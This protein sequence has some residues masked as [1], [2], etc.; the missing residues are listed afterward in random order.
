MV[1]NWIVK[2]VADNLSQKLH[3]KVTVKHVDFSL[4]NKMHIEGVL[5]ED[6]K[7]DTLLYA[8]TMNVNITDWFFFKD[9]ATLHYVGLT[10]AVINLNRTDSVWNYQFIADYFSSPKNKKTKS[11]GGI[12]FDLKKLDLKNI[13]LNQKDG[14]KGK[15]QLIKIQEGNIDAEDVS[16]NS[17]KIIINSIVLNGAAYAEKSYSGKKTINNITAVESNRNAAD[18]SAYQWNNAGWVIDI[19]Q[20]ALTNSLLQIDKETDRPVYTDKFDGQHFIFSSINGGF[21]NLHFEKDTLTAGLKLSTKEKSGFEIKKLEAALKFT[22]EKLELNNLDLLTNNSHITNYYSMQYRDGFLTS[23]ADYMHSVVMEGKF[24]NS[25]ISSND[26]AFFAPTLKTWGRQFVLKGDAKGTVDNLVMRNIKL[27]SGST[28]VDGDLALRGLP[29]INNTFIDFKSNNTVTNYTDLAAI[30]PSLKNVQQPKLSAL[31]NIKYK[32]NFIGFIND[33]VAYG[34]VNTNLGTI[35]SDVNMKLPA[36]KQPVYSGK[37]S[38]TAFN[39][40]QFLNN[41]LLGSLSMNGKISGSGFSMKDVDIDYDGSISQLYFNNYNYQDIKVKGALNK[42]MFEG[43]VSI[44]D[45]SLQVDN[46]HGTI[47]FN[48]KIPVFEVKAQLGRSNF[49]RLQLTNDDIALSGDFNLNF[50]GSNI[51]NF[52]GTADI[53]NA[54]LQHNGKQL[55]FDKLHLS[56][57]YEDGKK[58]LNF[59][60]NEAEGNIQGDFVMN[61]LP[62]AF[63]LI[64]NKYYPVYFNKPEGKLSPQDF[65]FNVTAKNV[66]EFVQLFDKKLRGFDNSTISGRLKIPE[67]EIELFADIPEFSYDKKVFTKTVVNTRS[68]GDSLATSIEINEVAVSDSFHMPKSTLQLLTYN[69]TTN[70]SLKTRGSKTLNEA[71]LNASVKLFPKGVDIHFYPSSFIINDKKWVLEKDGELSISENFVE[72][73][74]VKFTQG[75][76]AIVIS[77]EP[78]EGT[79]NTIVTANLKKVNIDDFLPFVLKKPKLEGLITG[80]V[81]LKNPFGKQLL[82]FKGEAENFVLDGKP[83]GNMKI[84]ANGNLFTGLIKF[85]GSVNDNDDEFSFD[86][87]YNLKDT[88]GNAIDINLVAEKFNINTLEPYLGGIFSDLKGNVKSNLKVSGSESHQYITGAV[89]VTDASLKVVYTQCTYALKNQAIIFKPDEIDFG[90]NLILKD[91]YG[92]AGKA[93]GKIYHE[94]FNNFIFEDISFSSEHMLLLNTT[95]KDNP[96]FYGRVV[97][98]ADMSLNGPVSNLKMKID[99]GPSDNVKDS[100]HFYLPSSGSKEIGTIDYIDF[101]QFGTEMENQLKVKEGT[102][103]VVDMNIKSNPACKVDVILDESTGDI[104]KGEGF[105]NLNIHV[106]NKEPLTMRGRYDITK[107]EYTFNFQTFIKKGFEIKNGYIEWTRDPYEAAI[108]IDAEYKATNVDLKDLSTSRGKFNQ[109]EN[110]SVIAHLTNTLSKPEIRF[111]FVLPPES[112]YKND[113]IVLESL[114]KFT[115]DPNEMNRQVASLLLFNTFFSENNGGFRSSTASFISGTAGQIIS[116]FLNNQ[117]AKFFQKIFNDPTITPYLSLNSNYDGTVSPELARQIQASGNFGLKKEYLNGRLIVSLGGNVD[118]NNPYI[119]QA[120]NTNVLLTP[121]ITVEYILTTDGKLR[122]LGFNRTSVDLNFGQRNRTGVSL[123]YQKDFNK[124]SE[125]FAPSEEKKRKRLLRKQQKQNSQ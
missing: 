72:A 55:S 9:K 31:G 105:G 17:K 53:S 26:L 7:Q 124:L 95:K 112:P 92:N 81:I 56:S 50:S 93:G 121:D 108:N 60:T 10:D 82:D 61:E 13:T 104:I 97:G 21:S 51:D 75:N 44:N 30:V 45:P 28:V 29:D 74:E 57:F 8:G 35:I 68:S 20:L 11:S 120:R 119:L 118:Y 101:I 49:K 91:K 103:I 4:F 24:D 117:F 46:L 40:G 99:G 80:R 12:E 5:V 1:Q 94:L 2:K 96:D 25:T 42:K 77:T 107:G 71:D 23:M 43:N 48:K 67:N 15:E 59:A 113:P 78:E 14:W 58:K 83:V 32:G 54:V 114:K 62:D 116:N 111:E 86:G 79:S 65:I 41:K 6:Q 47:D 76:Q 109:K 89:F 106:G 18:T 38:T 125:L 27:Q 36:G 37:L 90:D 87:S 69:G 110:I 85:S 39:L 73:S 84:D 19:R 70:V 3:A 64:L 88:T 16:F 98:N 115:Q 100:S 66:D 123:S 102:N 22:P 33:F 34:T 63:K 52:S 122:I